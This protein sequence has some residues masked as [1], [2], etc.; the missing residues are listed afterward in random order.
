MTFQDISARQ[1][2]RGTF[3]DDPLIIEVCI[4]HAFINKRLIKIECRYFTAVGQNLL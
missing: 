2:G 4:V 1:K 3:G